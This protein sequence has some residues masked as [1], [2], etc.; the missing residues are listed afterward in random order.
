MPKQPFHLMT[1]PQL[2][3]LIQSMQATAEMA[4]RMQDYKLQFQVQ[5]KL[6]D[7]AF[8]LHPEWDQ[9]KVK[10]NGHAAPSKQRKQAEPE[11]ESGIEAAEQET[12]AELQGLSDEE[13]EKALG[14]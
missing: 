3:A 10:G 8:I 6:V 9:R 14:R 2:K 13:L 1:K 7:L 12:I 4:G 11:P 5:C